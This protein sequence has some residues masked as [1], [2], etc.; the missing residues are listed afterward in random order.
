M[1]RHC[2]FLPLALP[3]L[4]LDIVQAYLPAALVIQVLGEQQRSR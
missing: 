3:V 2:T 1:A 4:R